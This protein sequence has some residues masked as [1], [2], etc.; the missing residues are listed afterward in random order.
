M[1]G[2]PAHAP[3]IH[4]SDI[5][6]SL[7]LLQVA[8]YDRFTKEMGK[9]GVCKVYAFDPTITE[10]QFVSMGYQGVDFHPWGLRGGVTVGAEKG[11]SWQHTLYGNVTGKL[12]T[13]KGIQDRLGHG[14][15]IRIAYLRADVRTLPRFH[16]GMSSCLGPPLR[17]CTRDLRWS[18]ESNARC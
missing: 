18:G 12:F 15:E 9:L 8:N 2:H 10:G 13:L 7:Y 11:D 5:D 3:C 14:A 17:L 16:T 4:V 1:G 6:R